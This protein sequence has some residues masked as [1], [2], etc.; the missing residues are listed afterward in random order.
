MGLSQKRVSWYGDI[1][2]CSLFYLLIA[3]ILLFAEAKVNAQT[4][5]GTC[6]F[7]GKVYLA[8]RDSTAGL[9]GWRVNLSGPIDT[10]TISD[11]AGH[12]VFRDLPEGYYLVSEETKPGWYQVQP[13]PF[14]RLPDSVAANKAGLLKN[15]FEIS[16]HAYNYRRTPLIDGGGGGA[17][18]GYTIPDSMV[19]SVEGSNVATVQED[20]ITYTAT[21]AKGYGVIQCVEDSN[22]FFSIG[23]ESPLFNDAARWNIGKYI[24][25]INAVEI[26]ND[27]CRDIASVPFDFGNAPAST[28]QGIL[29]NDANGNGRR[30]GLEAGIPGS[31]IFVGG[32]TIDST[33]TD[34][35]GMYIFTGL[36]LG[37]YHISQEI[38][39]GW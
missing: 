24:I 39:A 12:Y 2:G 34:S 31:K 18:T 7:Q 33:T 37:I 19:L 11:S 28:L 6:G 4:F 13:P 36:P 22:G 27:S 38:P 29:F 21:S 20:L 23:F 9:A 25:T 35:S 10:F 30:D 3:G 8:A 15:L 16:I 5:V 1:I 17:Y 14:Q 26:A 32:P